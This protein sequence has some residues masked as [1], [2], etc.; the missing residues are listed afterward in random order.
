MVFVLQDYRY[1]SKLKTTI[2]VKTGNINRIRKNINRI[3]EAPNVALPLFEL[4]VSLRA[5]WLF[6]PDLICS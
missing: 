6:S 3:L 2:E 5:A 4:S 1:G